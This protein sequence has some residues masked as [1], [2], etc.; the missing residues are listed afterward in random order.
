MARAT[1]AEAFAD[2]LG[3]LPRRPVEGWLSLLAAAVMVI[4]FGASLV[5]AG[6]TRREFSGDHGFLL[7]V[8]GVGLAFGF[9]SAKIGWGR[10]RTHLV[11]ALFAG[12]LLP[13]I[14][15]GLVLE[16]QGRPVGW[17][18]FGLAA[19]MAIAWAVAQQVWIELA[20]S[21]CRTPSRRATTTWSSGR[22]CGAPACWPATRSSGIAG[23]L[24]AVVVVGLALLGQHGADRP[25][26]LIP[27]PVQRRRRCSSS[28]GRT[29]SRRS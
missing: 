25:D 23:P 19:R 11:G 4:A 12:I 10:W 17:D 8:G 7:Y 21:A 26:Q 5:D 28:S 13:L 3:R 18:P 2:A 22:S 20:V 6:W 1:P 14:M 15:G 27:D 29:S 9:L 16:A 24:D